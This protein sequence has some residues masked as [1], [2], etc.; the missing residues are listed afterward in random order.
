M[1]DYALA[2]QLYTIGVDSID[3][4]AYPISELDESCLARGYELGGYEAFK[5]DANTESQLALPSFITSDDSG[6]PLVTWSTSNS[7]DI[8]AYQIR[9]S[10]A[11]SRFGV[12]VL[13]T[14]SDF[15]LTVEGLPVSTFKPK[16]AS[17]WTLSLADQKITEEE[18]FRYSTG[19]PWP[20]GSYVTVDMGLAKSFLTF[21]AS[22]GEFTV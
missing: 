7:A 13:T 11:L 17:Q 9:L 1:A 2:D 20:F 4:I 21:D 8:G 10:C 22:L 15:L 18:S 5:V 3:S 16:Y 14:Y 6:S 12:Q 19:T